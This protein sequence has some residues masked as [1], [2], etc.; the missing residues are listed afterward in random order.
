[1]G[2]EGALHGRP[3]SGQ[4]GAWT[5]KSSLV[6]AVRAELDACCL[7]I[8]LSLGAPPPAALQPFPP[9]CPVTGRCTSLVSPDSQPITLSH[10][11]SPQI[12]AVAALAMAGSASAAKN[13]T[14]LYAGKLTVLEK[15]SNKARLFSQ[16]GRGCVLEIDG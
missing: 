6:H 4:A 3:L 2:V 7:R 14:K 11:H 8:S 15:L 1:M 12:I 9:P 10:P 16:Q 5:E 13:E